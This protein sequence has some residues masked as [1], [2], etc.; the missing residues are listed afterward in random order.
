MS[1]KLFVDALA[2]TTKDSCAEELALIEIGQDGEQAIPLDSAA[3]DIETVPENPFKPLTETVTGAL[4]V[5]A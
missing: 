3:T 5:P 4:V 2:G 1:A